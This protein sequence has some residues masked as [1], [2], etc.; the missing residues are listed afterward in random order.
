MTKKQITRQL[1]KNL[2]LTFLFGSCL[3]FISIL[4][5]YSKEAGSLEGNSGITI[6][7]LAGI[8]WTLVLTLSSVTVFLNLNDQV[9][10]SKLFSFL[11]F[12][13]LPLTLATI[14]FILSDFK[15]LWQPFFIMTVSFLSVQTYFYRRFAKTNF[16][17]SCNE[18]K[19]T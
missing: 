2:L 3:M 16:D 4:V 11:T 8:F 12:F 6:F 18:Q 9:R 14:V 5:F 10:Q 15:D 19:N 13:F 17:H 1:S 7:I